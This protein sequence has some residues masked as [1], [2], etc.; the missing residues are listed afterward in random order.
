[1]RVLPLVGRRIPIVADEYA[2]PEKGTRRG[3]DHAGARLQRLRGRPAPRAA[4]SI[5]VL[6]AR[7]AASTTT[8]RREAY[9]GLDRFEAR[10]RD[11][12]RSRSAGPA[13]E[14]RAAHAT[15]CRTATAPAS[16]IE[17]WLTDQWY[18]DAETLAQPAIKA[19]EERQDRLRAEAVGE[20]LFRVDA[21]HPA[22]VHQPP[23]LVGPPDPGLVRPGR[24]GVRRGDRGRGQGR[25][26]SRITAHRRRPHAATRTCSTPGSPRR[27]GRSR[28]SAGPT[29]RRSWSASTRPT[30]WSPASTSSSSGSPG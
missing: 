6:D 3:Q 15:W 13:R 17:P 11:R 12:R 10:K 18:C 23:A 5:N 28:P 24:R 4:R 7:R 22:L 25:G 9:R 1:M 8:R 21:Q 2:D 19:V 30:C 26:G 29:R 27:C 20:H 14:D 16:P